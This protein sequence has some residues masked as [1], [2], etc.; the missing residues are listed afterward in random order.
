MMMLYKLFIEKD[1]TQV[2]I[3]PLGQSPDRGGQ[4]V[5]SLVSFWFSYAQGS[6][7]FNLLSSNLLAGPYCT[8]GDWCQAQYHVLDTLSHGATL[9]TCLGT[10]SLYP[11]ASFHSSVPG[12]RS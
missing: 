8:R 6:S 7:P 1:A 10:C 4:Y 9:D 2:E 11:Y 12:T 5:L 3:N